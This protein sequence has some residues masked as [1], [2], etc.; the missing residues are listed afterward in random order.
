MSYKNNWTWS[1]IIEIEASR[2]RGDSASQ[3]PGD[4]SG[5]LSLPPYS[6]LL[7]TTPPWCLSLLTPSAFLPSPQLLPWVTSWLRVSQA[8]SNC[9]LPFLLPASN[10]FSTFTLLPLGVMFLKGRFMDVTSLLKNPWDLPLPTGPSPNHLDYHPR[11]FKIGLNSPPSSGSCPTYIHIL[12]YSWSKCSSMSSTNV[13]AKIC[14]STPCFPG[15]D[16][17]S[18]FLPSP[19]FNMFGKALHILEG[20]LKQSWSPS[21]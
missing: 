13:V 15:C 19:I 5:L 4:C 17:T 7:L 1:K 20:P 8:A 9:P 18:S 21:L 3:K 14:L 6:L 10:S 16:S 11:P 12:M 2:G